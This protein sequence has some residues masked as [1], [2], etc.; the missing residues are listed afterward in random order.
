[1]QM[2]LG[3]SEVFNSMRA[4][5]IIFASLL[6][7]AIASAQTQSPAATPSPTTTPTPTPS[8]KATATATPASAPGSSSGSAS[9]PAATKPAETAASGTSK[10]PSA[11][12]ATP[13]NPKTLVIEDLATGQGKVATKGMTVKVHYT[14]W[15]YDSTLPNGRG[16]LISSSLRKGEPWSFLLGAGQVIKGWDEGFK[17]M[18]VGGKRRLIIPSEMAFGSR[19]ARTE[20]PPHQPLV[21]EIELLD[22]IDSKM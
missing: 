13:E 22:V 6:A 18:R 19:G 15:L 8:P 21:F 5:I 1:M 7:V 3:K 2:S 20:V 4:A 14:G 17:D 9:K 10:K 12:L 16:K 11:K